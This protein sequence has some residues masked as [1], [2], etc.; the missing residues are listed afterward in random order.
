MGKLENTAPGATIDRLTEEQ[1]KAYIS[2]LVKRTDS[3]YEPAI[4]EQALNRSL[5]R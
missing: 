3:H 2:S 5:C 1:L 4:I